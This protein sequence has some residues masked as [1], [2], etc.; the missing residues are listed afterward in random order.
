MDDDFIRTQ[1]EALA[2]RTRREDRTIV[3]RIQT[4][5]W[6][7]GVADRAESVALRWLRQWRPASAN[8]VLPACSCSRGHCALCN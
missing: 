2:A 3:R 6:P 5:C 4:A 8:L 1:I 7:G